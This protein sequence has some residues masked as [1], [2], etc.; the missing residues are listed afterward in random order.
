VPFMARQALRIMAALKFLR[1]K[2]GT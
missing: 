1:K 2:K